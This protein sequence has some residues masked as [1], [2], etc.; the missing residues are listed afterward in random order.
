M[1][2][3]PEHIRVVVV[4]PSDVQG[5][6][7]VIERVAD[8]LNHLF[9]GKGGKGGGKGGEKGTDAGGKGD[10]RNYRRENAPVPFFFKSL[11]APQLVHRPRPVRDSM[12]RRQK[13]SGGRMGVGTRWLSG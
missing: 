10:R 11:P 7:A 3:T 4:G 1:D 5:H 9:E 8:E 12:G 6:V 2:R 13:G